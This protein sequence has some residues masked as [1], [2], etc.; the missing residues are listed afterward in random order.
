MCVTST[1]VE[2]AHT[3]NVVTQTERTA[4]IC[5][6]Q[7][8]A[9]SVCCLIHGLPQAE[10]WY[11][12]EAGGWCGVLY[13]HL[14]CTSVEVSPP[15]CAVGSVLRGRAAFLVGVGFLGVLGC[16]PPGMVTVPRWKGPVVIV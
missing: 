2:V 3:L 9:G 14:G 12:L 6:W 5:M 1:V 7:W 15:R 4:V 8:C 13:H 16:K 10:P 11:H